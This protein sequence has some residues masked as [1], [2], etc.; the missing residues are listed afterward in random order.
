[1]IKSII[2]T[3]YFVARNRAL[4]DSNGNE[5]L[6]RGVS[7]PHAWFD[8]YNRN[9]SYNSLLAIS[10]TGVNTVRIV[11]LMNLFGG[12]DNNFLEIIIKRCI[13]LKM[14]CFNFHFIKF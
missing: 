6:I 13:E 5:F 4:Y 11:W 8:C 3:G 12:L 10:Q 14:V 9:Y 1:M 7:S 2:G